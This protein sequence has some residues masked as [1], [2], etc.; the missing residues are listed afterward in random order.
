M[1]KRIAITGPESTGKTWLARQLAAHYKTNWVPEFARDFLFRLNRPYNYQD[2][3][4]IARQQYFLNQKAGEKATGFLF[5][6]TE[7]I[8]TKIWCEVKYGKCHAWI[9][10]H[11]PKQKFD[12]YLIPDIDLP[13]EPDPQREHPQMRE[14]LMQLYIRELETRQFPYHIIKGQNEERLKNAILVISQSQP[15]N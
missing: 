15:E 7:L 10:D 5:C 11:I 4:L 1:T 3:L 14:K 13:W 8:V 12:L 9:T 6:D 2:I